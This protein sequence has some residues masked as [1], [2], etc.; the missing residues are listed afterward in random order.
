MLCNN[1]L[2]SGVDHKAMTRC[3]TCNGRGQVYARKPRAAKKPAGKV[4]V[5]TCSAGHRYQAYA[6]QGATCP[7]C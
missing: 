3:F 4:I 1:C 2:G 6:G 7:V 5:I